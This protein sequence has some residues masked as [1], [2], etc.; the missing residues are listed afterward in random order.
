M[1][2]VEN[3]NRKGPGKGA[4]SVSPLPPLP[5]PTHLGRARPGEGEPDPEGKEGECEGA[6]S[7]RSQVGALPTA[8]Q[9]VRDPG[10]HAGLG[11]L[12]AFAHGGLEDRRLEK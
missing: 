10:E 6:G 11:P 8:W 1:G 5:G 9:S 3:Q 2:Q 4:S 12:P 7:F